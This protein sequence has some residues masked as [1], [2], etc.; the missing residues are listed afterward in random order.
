MYQK[1][2]IQPL[3]YTFPTY[4]VGTFILKQE[5]TR[6]HASKNLSVN[7]MKNIV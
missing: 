5:E 4:S 1:H 7:A 2:R 6:S 3:G